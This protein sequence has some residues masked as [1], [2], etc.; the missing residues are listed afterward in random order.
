MNIPLTLTCICF[1][2]IFI[3][4]KR[5]MDR[6]T[7]GQNTVSSVDYNTVINAKATIDRLSNRNN[8]L[9]Y[10]NKKLKVALEIEEMN[11][12]LEKGDEL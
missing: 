6:I 2:V 12:T 3:S 8:E 10:E 5:Q 1:I 9:V 11:D 4:L 7:R